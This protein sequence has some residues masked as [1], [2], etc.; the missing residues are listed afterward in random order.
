MAFSF[1]AT[2]G[3][4]Q[5]VARTGIPRSGLQADHE[6]RVHA[7][8]HWRGPPAVRV[9][10]WHRGADTGLRGSVREPGVHIDSR[11]FLWGKFENLTI[12]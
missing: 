7:V 1:P 11:I 9:R 12:Y 8:G 2:P 4:W 10:F 5:C 3:Q 6:Q